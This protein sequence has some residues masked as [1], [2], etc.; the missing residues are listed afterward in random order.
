AIEAYDRNY[1]AVYALVH[2]SWGRPPHNTPLHIL[3]ELGLV[4]L[5]LAGLAYATTF[6]QFAGIRRG[7]ELYDLR[8]ALT[9]AL[10]ALGFVSLFIDLAN[11][12]YLWVVLVA[13]AQLRSVAQ[14]RAAEQR[15]QPVAPPPGPRPLERY[16]PG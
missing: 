15:S 9:A 8:V 6:R 16:A 14:A 4:G 2:Q 3:L 1:L 11:Y 5:L 13:I 7:D 10:L 12:K